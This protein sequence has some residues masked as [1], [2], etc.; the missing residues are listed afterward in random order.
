M[1]M[2]FGFCL[3]SFE[4]HHV[5][6][7]VTFRKHHIFYLIISIIT[8]LIISKNLGNFLMYIQLTPYDNDEELYIFT[9]K[10]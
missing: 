2:Y 3:I 1:M 10:L 6:C 8:W 9:N 4:Q 7:I 5:F